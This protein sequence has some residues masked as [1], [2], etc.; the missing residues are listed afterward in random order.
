MWQFIHCI[1]SVSA[2]RICRGGSSSFAAVCR[3][4]S[5]SSGVERGG[6]KARTPGDTSVR[7]LTPLSFALPA[8]QAILPSDSGTPILQTL[9]TYQRVSRKAFRGTCF[10]GDPSGFTLGITDR[11]CALSPQ[12]QELRTLLFFVLF[13]R[14][15]FFGGGGV[16][17]LGKDFT[18]KDPLRTRA[19]SVS[20][21]SILVHGQRG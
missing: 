6:S 8:P 20:K 3:S 4:T 15:F 19:S 10:Q 2:E 5:S 7:L 21:E 12:T 13:G 9:N 1:T 17:K 18:G 11:A 16:F 14:V